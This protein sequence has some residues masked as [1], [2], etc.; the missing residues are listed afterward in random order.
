MTRR[1]DMVTARQMLDHARELAEMTS[2]KSQSDLDSDRMLYLAV[3]Q[4]LQIVGEAA[5]R[6]SDDFTRAH[7]GI[8]WAEIIALRNRL[9]HGY[10]DVHSGIIWKVITDDISGLITSL[11]KLAGQQSP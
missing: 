5:N 8:P 7:A 6:L 11:E 4:L 10:N 2:G 3:L 1:D 9:I